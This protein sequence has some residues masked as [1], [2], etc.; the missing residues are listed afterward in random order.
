MSVD[1]L[2]C[3]DVPG[4]YGPIMHF[5]KLCALYG[6]CHVGCKV[7]WSYALAKAVQAAQPHE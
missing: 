5:G 4:P 6:Y 1:L 7:R 2:C 3:F